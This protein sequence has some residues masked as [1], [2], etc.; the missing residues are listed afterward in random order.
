MSGKSKKTTFGRRA[1]THWTSLG[2]LRAFPDVDV[3]E[4]RIVRDGSVWTSAGI[5]AGMDLALAF[6][7]SEAGDA[8]A[9]AIQLQAEYYPL[10]TRYGDAHRRDGAPGYLRVP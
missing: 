3:V 4:E 9:G 10:T 1:T 2:R 7:A 6:I 5:S 8:V